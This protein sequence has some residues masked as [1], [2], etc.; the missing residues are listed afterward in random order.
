[1]D[2]QQK[3][4]AGGSPDPVMQLFLSKLEAKEFKSKDDIDAFFKEHLGI[5]LN[6]Y[7]AAGNPD[8]LNQ[9]LEEERGDEDD[10]DDLEMDFE[11]LEDLDDEEPISEEDQYT[12]QQLVYDAMESND[13]EAQFDLM[14][15]A[16]EIDPDNPDGLVFMGDL[17][18][19]PD[20]AMVFYQM[21]LS[22]AKERLGDTFEESV[23]HFW[24]I[25]ETRPYM[26]AKSAFASFLYSMEDVDSAIEQAAEILVLNPGDN[27]GVRYWLIN[28][29]M[30]EE[31]WDDCDRLVASFPD[32]ATPI[33]LFSKAHCLFLKDGGRPGPLA[34]SAL[35]QAHEANG[36]VID[37][38]IG[39]R[40][41][42]NN[43]GYRYDLGSK[44]EAVVYAGATIDMW[45]QNRDA[46]T[47]LKAMKESFRD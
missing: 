38:L 4:G 15:Q 12:A 17:E 26:R 20:I 8:I 42:P 14:T 30:E 46:I 10:D 24:D 34:N 22:V 6:E 23:G 35:K 45:Q 9:L 31:R 40:K 2:D 43:A 37:Y 29:Y 47:W 16:L 41:L 28:W 36:W 18:D 19:D 33:W 11:D 5:G 21:A 7:L 13:P 39:R 44:E 25:P 3:K 32:E 1:M 27:L